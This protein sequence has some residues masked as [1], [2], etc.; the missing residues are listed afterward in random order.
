LYVTGF[1]GDI[2]VGQVRLA[3]F[4]V[5]VPVEEINKL[6]FE[7]KI[8]RLEHGRRFLGFFRGVGDGI[9]I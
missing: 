9:R 1:P 8:G 2:F 5:A 3:R 6:S 7:G 4:L